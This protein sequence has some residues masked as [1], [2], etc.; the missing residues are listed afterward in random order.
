MHLR[1]LSK[2]NT[3]QNAKMISIII[4]FVYE[5]ESKNKIKCNILL[6][7]KRQHLLTHIVEKLDS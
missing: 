1:Q 2:T 5:G 3:N 4:Q 7:L 6:R